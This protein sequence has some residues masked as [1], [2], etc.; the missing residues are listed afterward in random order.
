MIARGSKDC[1][2]RLSPYSLPFVDIK[3]RKE[4]GKYFGHEQGD[5]ESGRVRFAWLNAD[6]ACCWSSVD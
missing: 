3:I 1:P 6:D 2:F 5:D 4:S